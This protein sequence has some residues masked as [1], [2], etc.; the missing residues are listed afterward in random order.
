MIYYHLKNWI[1]V[2]VVNTYC[3]RA[4]NLWRHDQCLINVSSN[5][6]VLIKRH[7]SCLHKW[8]SMD[9]MNLDKSSFTDIL[10]NLKKQMQKLVLL[11][12]LLTFYWMS[13]CRC[14]CFVCWQHISSSN[15]LCRKTKIF[16]IST[17]KM[18]SFCWIMG[19]L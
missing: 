8:L 3:I 2:F 4:H 14:W 6:A 7:P 5:K 15:T 18:H 13:Y 17:R 9:M 19:T 12:I 1:V 11:R 10:N 16:Y